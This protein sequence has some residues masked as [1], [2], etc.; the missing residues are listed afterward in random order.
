[1]PTPW[2]AGNH[3]ASTMS[4]MA[5][6]VFRTTSDLELTNGQ[7]GHT[8]NIPATANCS[9]ERRQAGRTL[10]Y[11]MVQ[12][13]SS[14]WQ[15]PCWLST[16]L[17]LMM[18]DATRRVREEARKADR[19]E[20]GKT[21]E[22]AGGRTREPISP[23]LNSSLPEGGSLRLE[24]PGK[25]QSGEPGEAPQFRRVTGPV[26]GYSNS[27]WGRGHSSLA[28]PLANPQ[29]C[30]RLWGSHSLKQPLGLPPRLPLRP[31]GPCG[32]GAFPPGLQD[33]WLRVLPH[34]LSLDSPDCS[35]TGFISTHAGFPQLFGGLVS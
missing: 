30:Q 4:G 29:V 31:P 2:R 34:R 3:T 32:V 16:V 11:M 24:G 19:R 1:M 15:L 10:L 8:A 6:H 27:C 33:T 35:L 5:L 17:L 25:E 13:P 28:E 9:E 14:T 22:A 20:R 18:T 7:P 12:V 21:G 26:P 23:E